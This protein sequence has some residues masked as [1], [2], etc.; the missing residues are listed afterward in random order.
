MAAAAFSGGYAAHGSTHTHTYTRTVVTRTVKS[1][2]RVVVR[3]RT[4]TII[5]PADTSGYVA[6]IMQLAWFINVY[7]SQNQG[8]APQGFGDWN[9]GP[10]QCSGLPLPPPPLH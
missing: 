4:K 1:A 5:R 7:P 9:S 8:F 2:P 6:C 3:H 10:S